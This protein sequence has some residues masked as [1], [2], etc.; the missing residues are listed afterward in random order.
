MKYEL[1]FTSKL[2]WNHRVALCIAIYQHKK[3]YL[4]YVLTYFQEITRYWLNSSRYMSKPSL[5]KINMR[6][7]K[8]SDISSKSHVNIGKL[9]KPQ[10]LFL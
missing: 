4:R 3:I 9:R 8:K 2:R 5:R 1:T 6:D 7:K 10:V